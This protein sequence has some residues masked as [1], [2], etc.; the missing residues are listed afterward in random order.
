MKQRFV[1]GVMGLMLA[2]VACGEPELS[3]VRADG[4]ASADAN[5]E[6]ASTPQPP[7]QPIDPEVARVRACPAGANVRLQ[8]WNAYATPRRPDGE[9]W[10]GVSGGTRELVCS[11]AASELRNRTA[12]YVS[13]NLGPNT[14]ALLDRYLGDAYERAVRE[15]CG[16]AANW[17]QERFEGP[18][19]FA[20]GFTSEGASLWR[21][22][23]VQDRW[24]ARLN[25]TDRGGAAAWQAPCSAEPVAQVSVIDS[26]LAFNDPMATLRFTM[27]TRNPGALCDGWGYLP[28]DQGVIALLFKI[29][30]DRPQ[31]CDGITAQS[32]SDLTLE[33]R[34]LRPSSVLVPTPIVRGTVS[35]GQ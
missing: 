13:I 29:T 23:E 26:D 15:G 18:D 33:R 34:D 8:L 17:L 4:G 10:D 5:T 3:G 14:G 6:E 30:V 11:L 25:L 22:P 24:I 9:P 16:L 35:Q 21:T 12:M 27:P 19:M 1:L 32:L 20:D 7:P 28:G 31:Q 2:V